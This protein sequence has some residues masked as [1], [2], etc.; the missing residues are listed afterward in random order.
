[1]RRALLNK[2]TCSRRDK[3]KVKKQT[4]VAHVANGVNLILLRHLFQCLR[5][6]CAGCQ[7]RGASGHRKN[8]DAGRLI[9]VLNYEISAYRPYHLSAICVARQVIGTATTEK[10]QN[11]CNT[12]PVNMLVSFSAS[13]LPVKRSSQLKAQELDTIVVVARAFHEIDICL[14]VVRPATKIKM[15]ISFVSRRLQ[16]VYKRQAAPVFNVLCY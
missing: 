9:A 7:K 15:Q 10:K 4:D 14:V 5:L 11:N 2:Q 6:R 8:L 3:S 12:Q 16:L 1:M 13:H